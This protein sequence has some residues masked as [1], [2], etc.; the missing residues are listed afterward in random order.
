MPYI[1]HTFMSADAA[2]RDSLDSHLKAQ[3][4]AFRSTANI[5]S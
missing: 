1:R 2:K 5:G 4:D 3:L